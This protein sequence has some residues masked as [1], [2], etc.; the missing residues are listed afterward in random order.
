M[1]HPGHLSFCY[2]TASGKLFPELQTGLCCETGVLR[3]ACLSRHGAVEAT[4]AVAE[5]EDDA[6][7]TL[8]GVIGVPAGKVIDIANLTYDPATGV[9]MA[10]KD[11]E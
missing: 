7:R 10:Y 4:L 2:D 8:L 3:A 5:V 1:A 9:T 6:K 11:P